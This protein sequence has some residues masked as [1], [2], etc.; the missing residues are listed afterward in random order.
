MQIKSKL[1]SII[2]KGLESANLNGDTIS[3]VEATRP[4]FGD[5][6]FNGIMKI[7]KSLRRNPRE[8]ANIVVDSIDKSDIIDRVEVCRSWIYKYMDI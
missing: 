5:Y 3:V 4:Q 6:Q 7:A 2:A 8:L 1:N